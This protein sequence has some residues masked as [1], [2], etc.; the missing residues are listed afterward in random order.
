MWRT[1]TRWE[2]ATI[3]GSSFS[4]SKELVPQGKSHQ[5]QLD[6][7]LAKLMQADERLVGSSAG[8]RIQV[9]DCR[10]EVCRGSWD[11]CSHQSHLRE[12]YCPSD[13]DGS[14]AS[15][16]GKFGGAS[17]VRIRGSQASFPK[18]V[19]RQVWA[20]GGANQNARLLKLGRLPRSTGCHRLQS[21][22][23]CFDSAAS[24][25]SGWLAALTPSLSKSV[26]TCRGT[27]KSIT[28]F[29]L[30]V[31]LTQKPES[32]AAWLRDLR[33]VAPRSRVKEIKTRWRLC[34][35]W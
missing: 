9:A 27:C 31:P 5:S 14:M 21:I 24:E 26:R 16:V 3:E 4:H 11:A 32:L 8:H 10:I 23:S 1:R 35:R 15:A 17:F 18:K 28:N 12:A 22:I 25:R 30:A 19:L 29:P 20:T 6:R 2:F 7:F 33:S 34:I 13:A